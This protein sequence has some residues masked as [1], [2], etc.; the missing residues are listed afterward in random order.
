MT[1][2]QFRPY[3]NGPNAI[4]KLRLG[5]VILVIGFLSPLLIPL[6]VASDWSATTKSIISG[7]LAFGIPEL[8]M[9]LAI[10]VMGKPG[11]EY[12]K[13]KAGIYLKRFL[14][15]DH[16]SR[17]RYY[18]GLV[19]F[20]FPIVFGI[21]QPYLAHF[22]AV[23]NE[24][25]LGYHIALDMIFIIGIFVLGGEFWDKLSGLFHY[26]AKVTK[27]EVNYYKIKNYEIFIYCIAIVF[28]SVYICARK[29]RKR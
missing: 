3:K 29:R 23:L 20:S 28:F 22:I 16:V 8:F 12:I 18:L 11:Y 19:L 21:L 15:N 4:G 25:P 2:S 24:L 1:D 27:G 17:N 10:I 6:V 5:V 7:L 14:P 13:G 26:D 9:L